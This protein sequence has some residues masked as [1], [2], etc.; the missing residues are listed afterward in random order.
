MDS[1]TSEQFQPSETLKDTHIEI[2]TPNIENNEKRTNK[3]KKR[4]DDLK[5]P[6]YPP[7]DKKTIDW[8]VRHQEARQQVRKDNSYQFVMMVS[9]FASKDQIL[10]A[11]KEAIKKKYKFYSY[12]DSMLLL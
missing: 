7:V 10:T 11:Y 5:P 4:A 1:W 6:Y 9:A 2:T 3:F 12:G 8:E